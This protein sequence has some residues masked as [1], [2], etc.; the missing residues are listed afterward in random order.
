[1]PRIVP[2]LT[3]LGLLIWPGAA[4]AVD[5]PTLTIRF[6]NLARVPS[7]VL[8]P[9]LAIDRQI[10]EQAGVETVWLIGNVEPNSRVDLAVDI[11][12]TRPPR[13]DT[14]GWV[15]WNRQGEALPWADIFFRDISELA[16]TTTETASLLANVIAHELGHMLLGPKHTDTGLMQSYWSARTIAAALRKPLRIEPSEALRLRLAAARIAAGAGV[17]GSGG[18]PDTLR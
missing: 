11:V 16:S 14:L 13:R 4:Q 12:R 5:R 7:S 17:R 1:M 10:F 6:W 2:G 18:A 8:Q 15:Y 3:I 9:A